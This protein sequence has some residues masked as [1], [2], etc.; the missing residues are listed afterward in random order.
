MQIIT[1]ADITGDGAVH[2]LASIPGAPKKCKWFQ[3]T[4]LTIGS[5]P[6]RLGDANISTSRGITIPSGGGQ[7]VYP[8][9][10]AMEF[11]DLTEIYYLLQSSDTAQAAFFV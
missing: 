8:I 5:T 3:F 11:Y 1:P 9:A 6:G 2:T 10:I 4:G 7:V